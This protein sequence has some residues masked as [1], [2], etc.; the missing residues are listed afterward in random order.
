MNGKFAEGVLRR[1]VR[2][3]FRDRTQC[4]RVHALLD[5]YGVAPHEVE[6][7]RVR[8][9]ILKLAGTSF[10]ELRRYTLAA[11]QDYR[12]VLSWAEYPEQSAADYRISPIDK[13][14][15]QV[16]DREQ[17]QRWLDE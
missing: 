6:A 11:K 9:A 10:E 16:R 17:W 12:D 13:E 7:P 4:E 3:Q 14:K 8:L 5:T 15:L 1:K 2:L